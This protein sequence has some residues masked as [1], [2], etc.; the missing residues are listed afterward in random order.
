MIAPSLH[1]GPVSAPCERRRRWGFGLTPRA[2]LLLLTGFV[3][4]LPGIWD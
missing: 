2:I 3:W 1:L 4:L